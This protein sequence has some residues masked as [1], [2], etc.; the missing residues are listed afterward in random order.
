[1]KE[2]DPKVGDGITAQRSSWRF[3]GA[4]P[5]KFD[6]H[7]SRSIPGYE[8][9]HDR[10]VEIATSILT[11]PTIAYELGCST[12][13]LTEKLAACPH[14]AE[15]KIVGIDPIAGM[16][17]IAS[18]RCRDFSN[19]SFFQGDVLSFRY[20][21]TLLMVSYYTLQFVPIADRM[22]AV[23]RIFDS[24]EE[25]GLFILFEK[26][27]FDDESENADV[28]EQYVSF[29]KLQGYSDEEIRSKAES[30][31]GVLVPQ[32]EFENRRMLTAAG[33]DQIETIYSQMCWQ[34]YVARK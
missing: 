16:L 6:S 5:G 21:P 13:V 27:Y 26:I 25:D 2:D 28:N 12:G 10:V 11:R 24:M 4:V 33:F 23:Q 3:D 20:Q 32:T 29:K 17:E 1:M 34:G 7:V 15:T 9:G 30:L 18:Q 31:D 22:T 8:Y 19:V 14:H